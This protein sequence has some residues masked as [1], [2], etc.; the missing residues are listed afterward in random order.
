MVVFALIISPPLSETTYSPIP[1]PR[2]SVALADILPLD[3]P[4]DNLVSKALKL[5][6]NAPVTEQ[7]RPL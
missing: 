6:I 1:Q 2:L 5:R 4:S 7:S 3:K